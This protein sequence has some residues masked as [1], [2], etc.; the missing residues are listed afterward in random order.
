MRD[1]GL[2]KHLDQIKQDYIRLRAN[3][4]GLWL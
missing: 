2:N 3:E 4:L 1:N